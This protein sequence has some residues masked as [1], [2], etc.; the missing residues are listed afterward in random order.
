[1]PLLYAL[2]PQAPNLDL[3]TIE[4][5][6]KTPFDHHIKAMLKI[7]EGSQ[8]PIIKLDGNNPPSA[9]QSF[10]LLMSSMQVMREIKFVKHDQVHQEIMK[11]VKILELMK[12]QQRDEI[13]GLLECKTGIQ[14][15]AYKLADKHE[16]IME[17]QYRLQIRINDLCRLIS[18]KMPANLVQD[19]EFADKIKRLK[20]KVEKLDQDVVQIKSKHETQKNSLEKWNKNSDLFSSSTHL[21]SKQEETIKEFIGAMMKQIQG[22]KS[23]VHKIHNIIDY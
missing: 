5:L 17:R 11:R 21:P 18:L 15:K 7:S 22:L 6:P 23:D 14:E 19:K 4:P 13:S 3:K 12:N 16:D 2:S 9:T 1:M 10:Q 20:T 8:L